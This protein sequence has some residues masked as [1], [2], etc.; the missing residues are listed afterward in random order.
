MK[1]HHSTY[2][3][4]VLMV[5]YLMSGRVCYSVCYSEYSH[6]ITTVLIFKEEML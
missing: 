3:C 2:R 1:V 6:M 5:V 4:C